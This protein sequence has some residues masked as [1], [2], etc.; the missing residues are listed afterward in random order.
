MALSTD[1]RTKVPKKSIKGDLP[2]TEKEWIKY[3]NEAHDNGV[4]NRR[5][6][7]FQWILNLGYYLGYQELR[8]DRRTATIRLPRSTERPLQ[9]NRISSFID[10][11]LAKLTKNRP[12]PKVIPNTHDKEDINGAKFAGQALNHL[13]RKTDQE[14]EYETLIMLGL[15]NGTSFKKTIWDPFAGDFVKRATENKEGQ[16]TLDAAGA[17]EEEKIFMGEVSSR[18]LSAFNIIPADDSVQFVKDQPWMMERSWMTIAE[19]EKLYPHLRGELNPNVSERTDHEKILERLSSAISSTVGAAVHQLHDSLNA[20]VLVKS[21]WIKP[22]PEYEEGLV[23]VVVADQLA[24]IGEFPNNFGNNIYPFVKW[25]ERTDGYHF[26]GQ[27]TI[28][29]LMSIQKAY[30]RLKQKKLKNAYLM[31]NGKYLLAKGS[32]VIES[33][34]SDVEAEVI[35]YNPSVPKPEQMRLAPLPNYVVELARELVIDFRDVGGQRESSAN[36]GAGVT[37]GVAMQVSAELSD[38]AIAPILAR[39]SR[40]MTK[41]ANQQL[42]LMN[43]EYIEDR[44]VVILGEGNAVGV[45]WMAGTD[46][47]HATDV[48]IEVESMFPDF[49]GA[50]QQKL[51]DL[52][53]RNIITDPKM[54]LE[55][56]RFGNFDRIIDEFEKEEDPVALDIK[57]IKDGKQPE[58]TPFQNHQAYVRIMSKW[59]QTP[60]FLRLIPE[61]KDL[62]V[63]VLQ[64]HLQFL[65]QSL[66]NQGG[67]TQEQNQAAV[68]GQFGSTVP[69]GA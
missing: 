11:R 18:A 61:R 1:K 46:F 22:I 37:A 66:P 31:G 35:E 58:I 30:N 52:W 5:K 38:E 51:L 40:T 63:Q 68:G 20:D 62:A 55:A 15:I 56:F 29:R 65:V 32:Q 19:A 69:A 14:E 4:N 17:I 9:I 27:S 45:Q 57:L 24:W 8:F 36:P 25:T 67:A 50:K 26:W 60:E 54:F 47:R 7:E 48:H 28:E 39:L 41:V 2:E 64:G 53:D 12:I 49:R 43:E 3:V 21:M 23:I 16:L 10:A 59:I 34:L 13:W 33:A 44:K 42:I 6:F